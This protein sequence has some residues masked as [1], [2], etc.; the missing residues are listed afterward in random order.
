[1]RKQSQLGKKSGATIKKTGREMGEK[2]PTGI[3]ES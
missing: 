3:G 2:K 1:L